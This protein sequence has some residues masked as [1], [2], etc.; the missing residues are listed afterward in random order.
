MAVDDDFDIPD[1][2]AVFTFGKSRFADNAPSK[3]WIK[4]DM[5]IEL[6][7]GDEHT[8]VITESGRVFMIGSNGMGQLGLGSTKPVNKPSCVKS[9]KPEKALHIACGR[10]HTI[11]SCASGAV[12]LW[13]HNGDGQLGT[14][15]KED[16]TFPVKVLDLEAPAVA[17][18]AGC[19]HSLVLTESGELY[20]WGSNSEGQLGLDVDEQLTPAL[21]TLPDPL[22]TISCGYYHTVAVSASGQA[23]TWGENE[24]GK[25]GLPESQLPFHRQ[26]QVVSIPEKITQVAAGSA[27]TLFLSEGGTVYSC[28]S[29][30][31]GELGQGG[32]ELQCWQPQEV[33]E[34]NTG[35]IVAI[36]AGDNHSSAIT[37]DGYLLTW[38]CGRHGKLCQG[39]ENFSSQFIPVTVRRLR[40]I[41]VVLVGCGGCHTM[42]LGYRRSNEEESAGE[43][44]SYPVHHSI[45]SM[46]RARRRVTDGVLPPLKS[47]GLPP[48]KHTVLPTVPDTEGPA[49]LAEESQAVNDPNSCV[50]DDNQETVEN[51]VSTDESGVLDVESEEEEEHSQESKEKLPPPEK[52]GGR[53]ARFFGGLGRKKSSSAIKSILV[54][55]EDSTDGVEVATTEVPNN[56]HPLEED[57]QLES[58]GDLNNEESGEV[59]RDVMEAFTASSEESATNPSRGTTPGHKQSKTCIIL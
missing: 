20:I 2:G 31:S 48:I 53:F 36:S 19:F 16:H 8:A 22:I 51:G 37:D 7:C 26:P 15:D 13:G 50:T 39:E 33:V 49:Q 59:I 46:A 18:A 5:I 47:V 14:G 21:L 6:A 30:S 52:K 45:S 3:F 17:V 38:G 32:G 9:L 40:H 27:H 34:T 10:S 25:L 1:T 28:G 56:D 57:A 43:E 41:T 23:Y 24:H 29:G 4:N 44:N 12:Y 54:V 58:I 55:A 42:V 11:V 35:A